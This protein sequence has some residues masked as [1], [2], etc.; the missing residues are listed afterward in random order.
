MNRPEAM[1]VPTSRCLIITP[2]GAAGGEVTGSA[3]L[4]ETS[5]A[6]VLVDCGL[7]QGGKKADTLNK[8]PGGRRAA[9]VDAVLIT[10]AHLDHVG[11][12]PLLAQ[13]GYAGPIFATPATVQLSGL[14]LRDSAKVQRF[15]IER[16]NRRLERAGKPLAEALYT[17]DDAERILQRF[18]PVPYHE[19]VDVA[20]GIRAIWVEAGHILGSASLQLLIEDEGR[21]KRIVFSG[22]LGPGHSPM[23]REFEPFSEADAVILE[24]TYGDRDHRSME[25]TVDQFVAIVQEVVRE[26]GR[27]LVPTFAIGRAQLL[28]YLLAWMF[29][30]H[31]VMPFPVFLDSPMAIE[32]GKFLDQH[33]ELYNEAMKKFLRDG[34]VKADLATMHATATAEESQRLNSVPGPC[35]IMAG[36]GMCTGGRILHHLRHG[37]WKPE[38]HVIIA[39][40][41]TQG[42]LGRRLVDGEKQVRIFGETIRVNAKIHT[43]GGFSAHAGQS[44]LLQWFSVVAPRR[45]RVFLTHG[46]NRARIALAERIQALYQIEA[47]LPALGEKI[48]L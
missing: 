25:E 22:D 28:T 44:Q 13:L 9:E 37:L 23:L 2:F 46:E 18:R 26:R 20:R 10:H 14:V 30:E 4:V 19:P 39:G 31:K 35:F 5:Q 40:F 48:E 47:G 24:S 15:D 43:L 16:I 45:P 34:N 6:R 32:A 36:A 42:S 17:I 11:R 21:T 8:P 12:L 38:T 41:Q 27:I 3:Y 29:R 33:P 7:F 1:R